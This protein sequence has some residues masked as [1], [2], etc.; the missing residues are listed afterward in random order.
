[1]ILVIGGK[2]QGKHEFVSE[3]FTGAKVYD[4]EKL[5]KEPGGVRGF[6]EGLDADEG[7]ADTVVIADENASGIVPEKPDDIR[8]REEY[9]RELLTLSRE[10]G[11]VYRIF[12]GLGMK[13]K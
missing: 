7:S 8:L 10:A 5:L 4:F 6:L 9:N 1:M 13:I 3:H 2:Y 12:C 11:E